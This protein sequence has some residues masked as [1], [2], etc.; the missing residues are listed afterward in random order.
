MS[1]DL[2]PKRASRIPHSQHLSNFSTIIP[3]C[4]C[5]L[6]LFKFTFSLELTAQLASM[7]APAR[8]K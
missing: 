6:E 3:F 1:I 8:I 7:I 2:L 5:I 4:N